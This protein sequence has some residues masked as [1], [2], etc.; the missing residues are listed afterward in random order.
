MVRTVNIYKPT[1]QRRSLQETGRCARQQI[2]ARS[3]AVERGR[4]RLYGPGLINVHRVYIYD[5]LWI[6]YCLIR[7]WASDCRCALGWELGS[8]WV[9]GWELDATSVSAQL[10][11]GWVLDTTTGESATQLRFSARLDHSWA[12]DTTTGESTTQPRFSARLDRGWA[13]DTT[14]GESAT[15]PW[16][17][18]R[19]DRGWELD[20]TS[21]QLS[22]RLRVRA[23]QSRG[24]LRKENRWNFRN[25]QVQMLKYSRSRPYAISA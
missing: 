8:P 24:A 18:A 10:D 5:T 7:L 16:F 4:T 13:L 11:R 23:R 22:T 1:N 2:A 17:S 9:V 25:R 19:L 14:T 15:Q 21:V 3:S 12:L 6:A 20:V